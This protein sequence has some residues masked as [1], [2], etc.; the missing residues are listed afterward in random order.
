MLGYQAGQR[1]ILEEVGQPMKA[2]IWYDQR[3]QVRES[4]Y[5]LW[6]TGQPILMKQQGVHMFRI[7]GIDEMIV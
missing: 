7:L 6:N 4:D 3:F 5:R 1:T 2:T